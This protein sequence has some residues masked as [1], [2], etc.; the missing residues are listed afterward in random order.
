VQRTNRSPGDG[1]ALGSDRG[2]GRT[3]ST[4]VRSRVSYEPLVPA[5]V[6]TSRRSRSLFSVAAAIAALVVGCDGR[7]SDGPPA[8]SK[9]RLTSARDIDELQ[10]I[11]R[12]PRRCQA[13]VQCPAG[14]YCDE[15][16]GQ[17]SWDCFA[18]S[19][20]GAEDLV[21][22]ARGLC[23]VGAWILTPSDTPECQAVPFEE[24]RAVL[25]SLADD[26]RFCSDDNDCPCGAYCASD[27]TCRVECMAEEPDHV[28]LFCD[29]GQVCSPL[30][31]CLESEGDPEPSIELTIEINPS[32]LVTDSSAGAITLQAQV[33]VV[34]TS[35]DVLDPTHPASVFVGFGERSDPE[36][37]VMPQVR[38]AAADPMA[39]SC[40]FD[41]GW[42]F[43]VSSGSLRSDP[44]SIWIQVP[45]VAVPSDWTLEARSEWADLPATALVR[46]DAASFPANDPGT[47][48]G[49][50][51]WP[52][53]D[54][55]TLML[56]VTAAVTPT[57]V[58]LFE[59][60]RALLPHGHVVLSR[61]ATRATRLGWLSSDVAE[62]S[63]QLTIRMDLDAFAYQRTSGRATAT[64]HM[65]AHQPG[66]VPLS[67]D[68]V[69]Q[70]DVTAPSCAAPGSSCPAEHY[71][72]ST[73]GMCLPG[74]APS[75][76]IFP[77]ANAWTS[78]A[79]NS[80]QVSGWWTL[81]G[82]MVSQ[83]VRF[84]GTDLTGLERAYCFRRPSAT[85]PASFGHNTTE[86]SRDL[87]C[88]DGAPQVT[89][90]FANRTL[91]VEVDP[92]S[93]AETFNLLD[94]CLAD[95]MVQ[96]AGPATA[97]NLLRDKPCVSLGRLFLALRANNGI[98]P[99]PEA[100]ARAVGNIVRQWLSLH[101]FVART[102]VQEQEY[103]DA[104]GEGGESSSER[105]GAAVDLMEK[106]WR[107]WHQ[108]RNQ[109]ITEPIA[110]RTEY[111]FSNRPALHWS[112]NHPIVD[113]A[114][115]SEYD[116]DLS[117]TGDFPDVD[118]LVLSGEESAACFTADQVHLP[119]RGFTLM[120]W[121][122]ASF[123]GRYTIFQKLN[124][125]DDFRIEVEWK[126]TSPSTVKVSAIGPAGRVDFNIPAVA[127]YYAFVVEG[128]KFRI[129]RMST[130]IQ[131][132]APTATSGTLPGWG[133]PGVVMLG[134]T[135]P[136]GGAEPP[137]GGFDEISLWPRPLSRE[138][139]LDMSR[140]YID[141]SGTPDFDGVGVPARGPDGIAAQAGDE[142]STGVAAHIIDAASA[143]ADLLVAYIE[144][145]RSA[146]YDACYLG[147]TTEARGRV[148][149]RVG[150]ALRLLYLAAGRAR[151]LVPTG[152]PPAWHGR[153][154][155][156]LEEFAGKR[157]KVI[158]A[159][160][161]VDTCANPLGITEDDLPLFHGQAV[162][163][164]E[165]FFASSRYLAGRAR[166]EVDAANVLLSPAR[167]AYQQQRLSA[168]Q[169]ALSAIEKS[170][171]LRRLKLDYEST[172]RRFCGPRAGGEPLLP[173]F[174]SGQLTP[175]T[176]PFKVEEAGCQNLQGVSIDAVPAA[177]LRGELGAQILAIQSAGIDARNA[178]KDHNRAID[179]YNAEGEHCA[180]R[181]AHHEESDAIL[182]E[183]LAHVRELRAQRRAASMMGGFLKS[184]AGMVVNA[185]IQRPE[186]AV[187]SWLD[188][189]GM[190]L[191]QPA[192]DLAEAEQRAQERY[193]QVVQQRSQDL[194]LMECYHQAD[195]Y[196]FAIDAALD[197]IQSAEA[198]VRAT[199]LRLENAKEELAA[200]VDEAAGQI[201]VEEGL[202]RTPPHHHYWVD[203]LIDQYQRR[204]GH[205]R[206]LTY[207]AL[208]A[209][210]YESQ[211]S[212]G[213]RGRVLTA[214]H[215]A[216]LQEV[217]A[218]IEGR[219]SPMQGNQAFEVNERPVVLS[220]RD[221]ILGLEDL[222]ENESRAPGDPPRSPEQAFRLLL[223][224]GSA[225][226]HDRNNQYL[227]Q[228]I[229]FELRPAGW[230]ALS[231]AERTWRVTVSVQMDDPEVSNAVL[232]FAQENA[233]A[234][235]ICDPETPGL[236]E[237]A[238]IRPHH[239]LLL[240]ELSPNF[241]TPSK[242]TEMNVQAH[243]NVPRQ[244]FQRRLE[245]QHAA[246][247]GRGLYGNY[248]LVFPSGTF[249][250]AVLARVKDVLIRLDIVEASNV[251]L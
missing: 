36:S 199:F 50:L 140:S 29:S 173:G 177:C 42:V 149:G 207:L 218:D 209:V 23:E 96:P 113:V 78:S 92:E 116:F 225:R 191:D 133:E 176:C 107:V 154:L 20:C 210:E 188:G 90:P 16:S 180:R 213:L 247:A 6:D 245:G 25:E 153:Y 101:A 104:L 18:D 136:T 89:F 103:D 2:H 250:D 109:L 106:A 4:A 151:Q 123:E 55:S 95:L 200:L 221:D 30:G 165:R 168:F 100:G 220:L 174:L 41:G 21:C 236:L 132:Y 98:T 248:V 115:D 118:L 194:D 126:R 33:V 22:S 232:V 156:S 73:A 144:A 3:G 58:V 249:P 163:G 226:I 206:R 195:N 91:Q 204:M 167:A 99:P 143:H 137:S 240:G 169:V 212:L 214:R 198:D 166:E 54:G 62:D 110:D 83:D 75:D 40:E 82:T 193:Q 77:D 24:R 239:N 114:Q 69:R 84:R 43:N 235:Q 45:Q 205:A 183:H 175:A 7:V 13:D 171:R 31:R 227:G 230:S 238:R 241:T 129:Y 155:S 12:T 223:R 34:A 47:Y 216:R 63:Q 28:E 81:L 72:S 184:M 68:L 197:L 179:R 46:S 242:Y 61:D 201:A 192:Q 186:L 237:V 88:A 67:L 185:A 215:P 27:A 159:L 74:P 219:H 15:D 102:T 189:M 86:P 134:C 196:K 108:V 233:F 57:H 178:E 157:R 208:R 147:G 146:M 105:F 231:C 38:C 131:E 119:D 70:G 39:P 243:M 37:P 202:D 93:G 182:T 148:A 150:R 130:T 128:V 141:S 19:D 170:E 76:G 80:A 5:L 49:T 44:R 112:F 125:V 161:S 79:L 122:G 66:A 17:C 190:V 64:I 172:L 1:E 224:S 117:V 14:S 127:G 164:S 124:L 26:Q 160:R 97:A 187:G 135:L 234:S 35:L 87:V 222:A 158:E 139:L 120:G 251:E 32:I 60:T 52:Q 138:V 71:C 152:T 121:V 181:Q 229:R 53:D 217:L 9:F 203:D 48:A 11:K 51:A 94:E 244:E 142:Q 10:R 59:E 85:D 8:V 228:G 162:G 211:Q 145:E 246:F 111:R 65:R 56:D